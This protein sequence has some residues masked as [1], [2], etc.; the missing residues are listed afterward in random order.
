[1]QSERK[2]WLDEIVTALTTQ[3]VFW[4]LALLE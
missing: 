2:P 4:E 1:M 3:Q